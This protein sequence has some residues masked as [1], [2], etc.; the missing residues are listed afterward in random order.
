MRVPCIVSQTNL[1]KK[2]YAHGL[3]AEMNVHTMLWQT[4]TGREKTPLFHSALIQWVRDNSWLG[5]PLLLLVCC[6][7]ISIDS[8]MR[9]ATSIED[10]ET[11]LE[12]NAALQSEGA[13][14]RALRAAF[15]SNTDAVT[16]LTEDATFALVLNVD[17]F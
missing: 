15:P 12:Q 3:R 11:W 10:T 1:A 8:V 13:K 16:D 14:L 9:D 6:T 5:L 7:L 4:N 2:R 17:C